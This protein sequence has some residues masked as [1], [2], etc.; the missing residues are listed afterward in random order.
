MSKLN[1]SHSIYPENN[2][3]YNSWINDI[4]IKVPKM[5]DEPKEKNIKC[6]RPVGYFQVTKYNSFYKEVINYLKK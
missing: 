2:I 3:D 1:I 6:S 5:K 4:H